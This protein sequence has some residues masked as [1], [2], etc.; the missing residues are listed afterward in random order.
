MKLS[1]CEET[2]LKHKHSELVFVGKYLLKF[3]FLKE[4]NYI[5]LSQKS[6][7][8]ELEKKCVSSVF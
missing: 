4:N 7:K 1:L 8:T 5:R 2:L 3:V 6:F